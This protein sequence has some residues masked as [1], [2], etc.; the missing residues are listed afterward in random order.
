MGT[1][2]QSY[3]TSPAIWDDTVLPASAATS[4]SERAFQVYQLAGGDPEEGHDRHGSKLLKSIYGHHMLAFTLYGIEQRITVIGI[5]SLRQLCCM[6]GH[7]TDDDD[8]Y[9]A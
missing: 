5:H 9:D 7:A 8:D 2:S 6:P 4:T 3:G 1:P